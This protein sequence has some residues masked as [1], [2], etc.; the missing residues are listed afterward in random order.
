MSRLSAVAA[1]QP[2]WSASPSAQEGHDLACRAPA[3]RVSPAVRQ[4]ALLSPSHCTQ[5]VPVLGPDA[6]LM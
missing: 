3:A 6:H 2:G 5:T 1:E 4:S